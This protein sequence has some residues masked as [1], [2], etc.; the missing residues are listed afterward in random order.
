MKIV[1]ITAE[2]RSLKN[3]LTNLWNSQKSLTALSIDSIISKCYRRNRTTEDHL[4]WK[5]QAI[6]H[7]PASMKRITKLYTTAEVGDH[8]LA[9]LIKCYIMPPALVYVLLASIIDAV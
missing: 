7:L 3:S 8:A 6:F 5:K 9:L 2:V 4:L 1:S